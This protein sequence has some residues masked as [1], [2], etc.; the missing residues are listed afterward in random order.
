[1]STKPNILTVI[2]ERVALRRLGREYRG[3]CPFH[4][5]K[6]PSFTVNEEKGLFYCFSCQIGGDVYDFLQRLDD[7]GFKEAKA[8][9]GVTDSSPAYSAKRKAADEVR[10]WVCDKR[11]KLNARIRD[12]DEMIELADEIPDAELA[13]SLWYERRLVADL[14]DD[15]D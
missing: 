8:Q 4:G 1:S 3:L 11:D 15:L 6:N 5:D 13:E 9:L 2:G 7:V 10:R 14:R 12:L